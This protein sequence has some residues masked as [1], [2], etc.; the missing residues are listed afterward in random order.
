MGMLQAILHITSNFMANMKCI[1]PDKEF[2]IMFI[3]G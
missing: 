3:A 2:V 1:Q